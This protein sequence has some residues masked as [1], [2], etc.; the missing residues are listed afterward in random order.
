MKVFVDPEVCR[1]YANCVIE[2]PEVF[3]ISEETGKAYTLIA[4]PPEEFHDDVRRAV[5]ACPTRAITALE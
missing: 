3:D 2:S 5:A 1:E 4:D